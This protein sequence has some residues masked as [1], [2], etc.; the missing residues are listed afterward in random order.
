MKQKIQYGSDA[1]RQLS[2]RLPTIKQRLNAEFRLE[3]EP[4]QVYRIKPFT[5]VSPDLKTDD[6]KKRERYAVR[7]YVNALHAEYNGMNPFE[8]EVAAALDKLGQSWCR[9]PSRTGY[10]IPIPVLGEGTTN[11]YPDFLLWGKKCLWAIDPKGAHLL[12]D[13]I[14]TKL[15]G[16]SDVEGLPTKI[17]VALI[18]EGQYILGPNDR[19]QKQGTDGCTLIWKENGIVK[20]K[21]FPSPVQLVASLK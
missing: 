11:F 8:V 13:A 7:P 1:M 15:L 9:N 20:F 4:D 18:S 19:P 17:R 6:L 5:L 2:D 3:Y 21:H 14:Y 10:S 16:V 12:T